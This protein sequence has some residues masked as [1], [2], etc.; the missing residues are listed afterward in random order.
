MRISC[1]ACWFGRPIY[2][3]EFI[4]ACG[5]FNADMRMFLNCVCA[6]A[7]GPLLSWSWNIRYG[8]QTWFPFAE[9]IHIH[10]QPRISMY[11][12]LGAECICRAPA[13][14]VCNNSI[15]TNIFFYPCLFLFSSFLVLIAHEMKFYLGLGTNSQAFIACQLIY[16]SSIKNSRRFKLSIIEKYLFFRILNHTHLNLLI[17]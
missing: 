6:A 1:C 8:G 17:L 9:Q 5:S 15:V 13:A 7:C 4:Y 14:V 12:M 3:Y 10:P 11:L 2:L 16:S